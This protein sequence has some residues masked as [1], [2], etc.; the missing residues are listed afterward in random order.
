M[1]GPEKKKRAGEGRCVESLTER[2]LPPVWCAINSVKALLVTN[3]LP[4][5]R[6]A[7]GI[8]VVSL[9]MSSWSF[10]THGR[11]T[12]RVRYHKTSGPSRM[13]ARCTILLL[14]RMHATG[15]PTV[16]TVHRPTCDPDHYDHGS[17]LHISK[18]QVLA[19]TQVNHHHTGHQVRKSPPTLHLLHSRW[20]RV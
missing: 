13:G 18:T 15:T 8:S 4:Q 9:K 3:L 2:T 17:T 1:C 12:I 20:T 7:R 6:R 19:T 10:L 14:V 16:R 11:S 5:I